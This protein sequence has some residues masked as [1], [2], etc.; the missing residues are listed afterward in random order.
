MKLHLGCGPNIK[1]GFI[2]I[3]LGGSQFGTTGEGQTQRINHDLSRGLPILDLF[4]KPIKDIKKVISCHFFEH[5]MDDQALS[6]MRDCFN[7]M[8]SGGVFRIAVPNFTTMVKAYIEKDWG[9]FDVLDLDSISSPKTRTLLDIMTYGLYQY[10]GGKAEH[11]S[12]WDVEKTIKY[13]T[14]IGF[15]DPREVEYD[16]TIEPDDELRR[17]YTFVCEGIKD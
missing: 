2:N 3:D 8:T 6:L 12:L 16:S 17:R 14:Y 10:V 4:G 1:E 13:L 11:K 9:F 15:S 5:I 7:K